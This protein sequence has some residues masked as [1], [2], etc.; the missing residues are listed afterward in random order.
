MALNRPG[1]GGAGGDRSDHGLNSYMLLPV[2]IGKHVFAVEV[3]N[4]TKQEHP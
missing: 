4:A 3:C 1:G 2:G